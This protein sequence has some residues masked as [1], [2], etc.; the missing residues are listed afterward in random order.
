MSRKLVPSHLKRVK[1]GTTSQLDD[2]VRVPAEV[3]DFLSAL[4]A[5]SERPRA[6]VVESIMFAWARLNGY[7]GEPYEVSALATFMQR[8]ARLLKTD[9]RTLVEKALVEW[10]NNNGFKSKG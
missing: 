1:L 3:A 5:K 6:L 10:C 7:T 9:R 2:K 8:K 4:A